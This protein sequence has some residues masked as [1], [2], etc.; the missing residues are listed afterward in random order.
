MNSQKGKKRRLLWNR[1][2]S[3]LLCIVIVLTAIPMNAEAATKKKFIKVDHQLFDP[4]AGEQTTVSFNLEGTRTVD[5]K[6]MNQKET[7]TYLKK[8]E[9]YEGKYK[10]Y[11]VTW[12]GKDSKGNNAADGTY[13]IVVQP[14]EKKFKKGTSSVSVSVVNAASKEIGIVPNVKGDTFKIYGA[15]GK[16]QGTSK[17]TLSVSQDG[18]SGSSINATVD[19]TMWYADL[20]MSAYSLYQIKASVNGSSGNVTRD[21]SVVRHVFR[22]GDKMKYLAAL[23][24]GDYTKDSNILLDNQVSKNYTN[25]GALVGTNILVINPSK[26]IAQDISKGS[27][28]KKQHLGTID[29]LKRIA[30]T[31]PVFLSMGNNF[32]SNS[33]LSIDGYSPLEFE[34]M[35]NTMSYDYSE[36]G[37]NWSHTYSYYL[38]DM[39]DTVAIVF[40]DGH[41]EYYKKNSDGSYAAAEG[42]ARKLEKKSDGSYTL[43]MEGTSILHFAKEGSLQEITDLNGNVLKLTYKKDMLS[44]VENSSGYFNFTYNTDGTIQSI[45]DSGDRSISYTYTNGLVTG[46]KDVNGNTTTYQYDKLN[47]LTKVISPEKVVLLDVEYD[48]SDRVV[49]KTIGGGTYQYSYD[50]TNRDIECTEP[51]G[52]TT[53]FHYSKDYQMEYEKDSEGT[54][55][56]YY[57]DNTSSTGKPKPYKTSKASQKTSKKRAK[58][59]AVSG[60]AI[61]AGSNILEL[62]THN[63]NVCTGTQTNNTLYPQFRIKNTSSSNIDLADVTL[64]YYFT[65]DGDRPL[66]FFCDYYSKG[67][68]SSVKGKFVKV[69]SS[70][71]GTDYY[72]EVGFNASAGTLTPGESVEFH[73]R[74]GKD[75]WDLFTPGDD[76]SQNPTTEF[77][78]FDQVD[79][80]YQGNL[81]WGKGSQCTEDTSGP[82]EDPN[83]GGSDNNSGSGTVI[84]PEEVIIPSGTNKLKLKMYN[85]GNRGDSTNTIHPMMQLVNTGTNMIKL[86]DITIR[87]YYTPDDNKEQNYWCDWSSEGAQNI[88]GTFHEL[89]DKYW[90][91]DTYLEIG[92]K[93]NSGYIGISEKVDIHSRIAKQDWS[94]YDITND[95]SINQKESLIDWDKVDVFVKGVKVWGQG[96]VPSEE[97]QDEDYI[98]YADTTK[99]LIRA[100]MF[101]TNTEEVSNCV[102]PRYRIYNTGTEDIKLSDLKINYFYTTDDEEKQIFEPDWAGIGSDFHSNI[103]KSDITCDFTEV[104]DD[105]VGTNCAATIGFTREDL[106]LKPGDYLELHT[107]MHRSSWTTYLQNNDFSFN[108]EDTNYAEWNKIAVFVGDNWAWGSM[109]VSYA[110]LIGDDPD[111]TDPDPTDGGKGGYDS[112]TDKAGNQTYYTYDKNGNITSETDAL[113]YKTTY[114]YNEFNQVTSMTD[115]L[116]NT[117]TYDYDSK[118]NLISYTDALGNKTTYTYD[119]KGCLTKTT[120]PDGTVEKRTYDSRGNLL[121][122]TDENGNVTK[123]EYDK[124][125]RVT[126]ITDPKGNIESYEYTLDSM[127]KKVT[128]ALGNT[129]LTEY[130]ADGQVMKDTNKNGKSTLYQYSTTTGLLEQSTD[131]KSNITKY[132]YDNMGNVTVETAADGSKTTNEYD[133]YGRQKAEID[134]LG[135]RT[136]YTYDVNGNLT[137]EKD[138]SGNETKYSYDKLNRVTSTTDAL[139]NVTKN[140]YDALGRKIKETDANGGVTSTDYDPN[141]NV[142]AVTDALGHVTKNEYDKVGKLKSTIDA[143]GNKT[144][145]GY[146]AGGRKIKQTNPL[147]GS[148]T[149]GYDKNDNLTKVTDE[150]GNTMAYAYDNLNQLV[151]KTDALGKKTTYQYDKEGNKVEETNALG[152]TTK[153]SYDA[154]GNQTKETDELG[155]VTKYEYDKLS[156]LTKKTDPLGNI[157]TYTYD[158]NGNQVKETDALGN[159]SSYIYDSVNKLIKEI[160]AKG[161]TTTYTYDKNGNRTSKTDAK[162]NKT[163]YEYDTLGN[164]TKVE[165]ALGHTSEYS[166]DKLGDMIKEI[167]RGTNSSDDQTTTYQY[168]KSGNRTALIDAAGKS[169][170]YEYDNNGQLTKETAKDGT[171]TLYKYDKAGNLSKKTYSDN[172]SVTYVYDSNNRLTTMTDWNGSTNY[173]YNALGQATKVTDANNKV[174]KYTWTKNGKKQSMTY[175][176]G[177]VVQYAYDAAGNL[178][179][180]TDTKN[181]VTTYNYDNKNRLTSK[182]LPNGTE[183][184]YTYD[185]IGQLTG[186]KEKTGSTTNSSY[187][188][189]YDANGN[190]IKETKVKAGG[191]ETS[192]YAYDDLNQL[193]QVADKKGTRTYTY[194][195]FNNRKG[196][197]ETGKDK[198][199]YTYNNVNELVK[200]TQGTDTKTYSYD[201]RGNLSTK[202]VNGITKATY[203]FDST[204][205]L[206]SVK[207]TSNKTASKYEYDGAGNRTK[208]TVSKNNKVVSKKSYVIDTMSSYQDII[209][210]ADTVSGDETDFTYGLGLVSVETGKGISYYRIDEKNSV[211]EIQNNSGTVK[212][213]IGYDE[214]GNV[215]NPDDIG[216][217]GNIFSYTGHVYE[218]ESSLLY[219]KARYYDSKT[220]RFISEDSNLGEIEDTLTKNLYIY[221][222]ENPLMYMDSD[223]HYASTQSIIN[224]G[225]S[226]KKNHG[227]SGK[228]KG[229]GNA[230]VTK[231]KLKQLGWKLSDESIG[232]LNKALVTYD[233]TTPERIRHFLSQC[234]QESEKG[235]YTTELGSD[236]YLTK[237]YD[238]GT[239]GGKNVGNTQKG[240]GPRFRGIGY[241]QVTGRS[242]YQAMAKETGDSRVME[243]YSYVRDNFDLWDISGIWW[244]NNKMNSIVD[245]LAGKSADQQVLQVSRA[246]NCGSRYSKAIPNGLQN[247]KTYYAEACKV[248]K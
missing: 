231:E 160:D 241:I 227:G 213:E 193:M 182:N 153:Y 101:N 107:R 204:N 132:Q 237:H 167:R 190:R 208:K 136:E 110:E 70:Q 246:V 42:I 119:S 1:A 8:G 129:T 216:T 13:K 211:E 10:T 143:K 26:K 37:I 228:K 109:P 149:W 21:I 43:T 201:A 66:N 148:I 17:V 100:E 150:N 31:N 22:V 105:N 125:N 225:G 234:A 11:K 233:I 30:S 35:Y 5:I 194:D 152:Y 124:L 184:A 83:K 235:L 163:S 95:Y 41:S 244:R 133:K 52:N 27:K 75:N 33:D 102:A 180:V 245:S 214:F 114:T 197:E 205:M 79:M 162:G 212:A 34:R 209:A 207:N 93:P 108:K 71:P 97:E 232:Q 82:K 96:V 80:F 65:V 7:V 158:K 58:V 36:F 169:I 185:S 85:T 72:M 210:E 29:E 84:P 103:A 215:E 174:V 6:V 198:I 186:R 140:E 76:Y 48:D 229:T 69:T 151:T 118:G 53:T 87:Y 9:K 45:V 218:T 19:D 88:T 139:G 117:V 134:A 4:S 142:V 171:S 138:A 12:D 161:N 147:A 54:I 221:C 18:K 44:K 50:D 123:Y 226:S 219:V 113:G 59:S 191:T 168:D 92:F 67:S 145:Y 131:A 73:T 157:Q 236:E 94:D 217:N 46:F 223:G 112:N 51:N 247:R 181:G 90:N 177:K 230:L 60:S 188:Y 156:Q 68:N 111:D 179:K 170:S 98:E 16:N 137:A 57:K 61:T 49:K 183:S 104:G 189:Q 243:G 242:N 20:P 146:D 141:G 3:I 63:M 121:T 200:E 32:Y 74:I 164:L 55:K 23:Y 81:V 38:Q 165:D 122:V 130:N 47:R 64:R 155:N 154:I 224:D 222:R 203:T 144:T 195:E 135:A 187:N 126:K 99:N 24:Y 220:G 86:E 239:A 2:L 206:T 199:T 248:I 196:K 106:V 77:T 78:S 128:D 62:K 173:T 56:Y 120:N 40:N 25:E 115:A 14:T 192:T 176:D 178:V 172:R 166:Y 159:S 89:T 39:G 202:K 240:D 28:Q 116:G 15:G 127:I 91:A 175:P 238:Q